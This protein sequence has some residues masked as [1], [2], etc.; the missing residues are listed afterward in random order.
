F[1]K[2]FRTSLPVENEFIANW[3][4]EHNLRR[5]IQIRQSDKITAP[6][7]Y[8]ILRPVILLPKSFDWTDKTRLRF[9]LTHEYVH[10]RRFDALTKWLLAF[11]LCVHWFNPF[12]WVVYILANRDL[13]LSCDETVLQIH[14]K[15]LKSAYAMTLI[16]MEVQKSR[17]SFLYNHF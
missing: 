3:L 1:K 2:E 14:G 12:V 4:Q 11:V 15:S 7:T 6:L 16:A 10:I 8:G 5:P 13:E 9:I 17:L